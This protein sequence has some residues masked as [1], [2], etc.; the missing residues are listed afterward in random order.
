MRTRL[1]VILSVAALLGLY[2]G[3]NAAQA[4]P[5]HPLAALA[6]SVLFVALFIG[7]QIAYRKAALPE[8]S[9]AARAISWATSIGMGAWATFLILSAMA[10]AAGFL[11]SP[12]LRGLV[13][14][15]VLP[16]AA[17]AV[18]VV[19]AF[20]GLGQAV[21]GPRVVEVPIA[22]PGLAPGLRGLR[23]A[24]I[25]DL[26]AGNTIER[27]Y[28]ES[29]VRR[30]QELKPDLIA[31]TGDLADGTVAQIVRRVEPL[32]RLHAP[33]GV[34]YVTGNHEYYWNA[35]EWVQKAR[36]LGFTPLLNASRI[37]ER[38]GARLFIAGVPDDFGG[39]FIPGHKP[40]MAKAAAGGESCDFRILLAHRPGAALAAERAGFDLQLSGHTHGGQFFPAS[41]FIG[42]FHRYA[43]GLAR[44]GR[45][46]IYVNPGTG[47]WGPAHRFAV[48]AE[49]TLLTLSE[50]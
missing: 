2:A 38:G 3:M 19:L 49:I 35:P 11:L 12:L 50:A 9:W 43:R 5:A 33:L 7:W 42:L 34:Y 21:R 24:Q 14:S 47:Y 20:L 4:F 37:L 8:N 27:G 39:A 18:A 15:R 29:I 10:A 23:I 44:R 36:E 46:Q 25:S 17:L 28:V 13:F 1:L 32:S 48:P 22:V 41:L 16:E 40:D 45:L 6:G 30:V 31:V 26:H